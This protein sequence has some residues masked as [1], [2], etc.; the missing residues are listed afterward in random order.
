MNPE[1]KKKTSNNS[2][3]HYMN[4]SGHI[5]LKTSTHPPCTVASIQPYGIS[6]SIQHKSLVH[7]PPI[8]LSPKTIR[9]DRS[10]AAYE[11]EIGLMQKNRNNSSAYPSP[12]QTQKTFYI[13]SAPNTTH[14]INSERQKIEDEI[15]LCQRELDSCWQEDVFDCPRDFTAIDRRREE[16]YAE[17]SNVYS[18]SSPPHDQVFE[19]LEDYLGKSV[20]TE[21]ICLSPPWVDEEETMKVHQRHLFNMSNKSY[22][23]THHETMQQKQLLQQR[24]DQ[25]KPNENQQYASTKY[26]GICESKNQLQNGNFS[27][28]NQY[29]LKAPNIPVSS[30]L[31]TKSKVQAV[32]PQPRNQKKV[33]ID[34]VVRHISYTEGQESPKDFSL[35][36]W[37]K[38]EMSSR[39]PSSERINLSPLCMS[40]LASGTQT[41]VEYEE[42]VFPK[43]STTD[44]DKLS[45]KSNIKPV[46]QQ[47][48]K[49][50]LD[51]YKDSDALKYAHHA[52]PMQ[53]ELVKVFTDGAEMGSRIPSCE[54]ISLSPL[55]MSGMT[56]KAQSGIQTPI[57]PNTG[58]VPIADSS[59]KRVSFSYPGS[60]CSE[61]SY[62][63]SGSSTTEKIIAQAK[64]ISPSLP[65]LSVEQP[66]SD[67]T[68]DFSY[69]PQS[70]L[71]SRIP[72]CERIPLSPLCQS[73]AP[74]GCQTPANMEPKEPSAEVKYRSKKP[75]SKLEEVINKM[76]LASSSAPPRLDT[77]EEDSVKNFGSSEHSSR[78]QSRENL[79]FTPPWSSSTSGMVSPCSGFNSRLKPLIHPPS[80][81]E[82]VESEVDKSKVDI[83]PNSVKM[84]NYH[85]V[86]FKQPP[87][88][89]NYPLR[90]DS[91]SSEESI[92]SN[93]TDI[94]TVVN[95]PTSMHNTAPASPIPDGSEE[96][97]ISSEADD[98]S[99]AY[100]QRVSPTQH[101]TNFKKVDHNSF[102][103]NNTSFW[104]QQNNNT[105]NFP[106]NNHGPINR[107]LA[108]SDPQQVKYNNYNSSVP[109]KSSQSNQGYYNSQQPPHHEFSNQFQNHQSVSYP[110]TLVYP[111][112]ARQHNVVG[113]YIAQPP[114]PLYKPNPI[115]HS[116][117]NV[118]FNPSEQLNSQRR[119]FADYPHDS[120]QQLTYPVHRSV[121]YHT[122]MQT[123]HEGHLNPSY[124]YTPK[125]PNENFRTYPFFHN[126]KDF[127]P[128]NVLY[129]KVQGQPLHSLQ[130]S[131]EVRKERAYSVTSLEPNHDS[132]PQSDGLDTISLVSFASQGASNQNLDTKTDMMS[133][134]ISMLGTHDPDDMARTLLAM[135]SSPDSCTA[136][137]Q[138]GCVP[139]LLNLLHKRDHHQAINWGA[140]QRAALALHNIIHSNS[141]DRRGKREIRVLRLLEI[142]RSHSEAILSK[143]DQNYRPNL[144]AIPM[145]DHGPGPAVAA[146]MKLSFE[147]EHKNTI[148]ELGGLQVIGEILA[149]DYMANSRC[150]DPYSIALRKYAGMVLINLTYNDSGNKAILSTLPNTIKAIISQLQFTD[151]EDLVQVFAGIIRNVSW[152]PD[153]NTQQALQAANAV[154]GLMI[155]IQ[156]LRSEVCI[157]AVLSAVWNLS[158]H[159]SENKEEICRTPGSLAFL[160]YALNYCSPTKNLSIIENAGGILRNISSHIA[161]SNEY[162]SILRQGKCMQTLVF[163]LRS[164]NTRIV[165]NSAGILWNLSA[166]CAEDQELLWELGAVSVL[167][168]LVNS[169]H[170]SISASSAAALRN[171]LAVKPGSSTD[172]ESLASTQHNRTNSLPTRNRPNF[173]LDPKYKSLNISKEKKSIFSKFQ[174]HANTGAYQESITSD[175]S[176]L[177]YTPFPVSISKLVKHSNFNSN[178]VQ[179]PT[180]SDVKMDVLDEK[181]SVWMKKC[182][183]KKE[184][185]YQDCKLS[186][187]KDS[188][189]LHHSTTKSVLKND[190]KKKEKLPK[191]QRFSRKNKKLP[192]KSS[193]D[194]LTSREPSLD[195][196]RGND[197][198]VWVK[199]L[200]QKLFKKS[201]SSDLDSTELKHL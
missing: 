114:N 96:S 27:A 92:S 39:I 150:K 120:E 187:T 40:A 121:G 47:A 32:S 74:S 111:Q 126:S 65:S 152:R 171:L 85:S 140:R 166:R 115:P 134:L 25:P 182:T 44:K 58:V 53:P 163:Q 94:S 170:S 113:S 105:T 93:H 76:N 185:I 104:H 177:V 95:A 102:Q 184:D 7:N 60:S 91:W 80:I 19:P 10:Q 43:K 197:K 30:A 83:L 84:T 198:N 23:Q 11:P 173:S 135:S 130:Q 98:L 70:E 99:E 42:N 154:R 52:V 49:R 38:S 158:A 125:H 155:S 63:S 16:F 194:S 153:K 5:P 142:I 33:N 167:K 12:H 110:R 169:K 21:D 193:V 146:I 144:L 48:E 78:M 97:D 196:D 180:K 175:E 162:R 31:F 28:V 54:L 51:N 8:V 159:S 89:N 147:E 56:S 189:L 133:S 132:P 90:H 103:S 136:M 143:G 4:S 186:V 68:K 1:I 37:P 188:V 124:P 69:I 13:N 192:I 50:P 119:D 122:R 36:S 201:F 128:S 129:N 9:N 160:V 112:H 14:G 57:E 20:S 87:Q 17:Q 151:E 45:V 200:K 6:P 131:Q 73:A 195:F 100:N 174:K 156:K 77:Y 3:G 18:C 199:S 29:S 157:R 75:M 179:S 118:L 108:S 178:L 15:L 35:S 86:S 59:S 82:R 72:S 2:T 41:P 62:E 137:R 107:H 190:Q 116:N 66:A 161:V 176:S 138:S 149:V 191:V 64:S 81:Q 88:V 127:V 165:S 139:L 141:D 61:K 34:N 172:T 145:G 101:T 71:G 67:T 164:T 123:I 168:N 109:L 24:Q 117:V 22:H 106:P 183:L 55:T 46:S 26:G 148:C 79:Y 181:I